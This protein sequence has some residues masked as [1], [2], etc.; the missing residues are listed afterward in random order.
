MDKPTCVINSKTKRAV[1]ADSKLGKQ[2]LASQKNVK[3]EPNTMYKKPIGPVKPKPEPKKE[4]PKPE[5]KKETPKPKPEPK[6][7]APK[8]EPKKETPK[9]KPEPKIENDIDDLVNEIDSYNFLVL[10]Y[11]KSIKNKKI[12]AM[13]KKIEYLVKKNYTVVP[14]DL[15]SFYPEF[16]NALI[17][18]YGASVKTLNM[19]NDN[20]IDFIKYIN[21][22][23]LIPNEFEV[24][25]MKYFTK[26]MNSRNKNKFSFLDKKK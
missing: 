6:K 21:D 10:M 4:A 22:E 12:D 1:K 2:I 20:M 18:K 24:N 5:P 3:K 19:I 25:E 11:Q 17:D 13:I 26:Y 9:P 16:L 23:A 7:E 14:S 8:P 15:F